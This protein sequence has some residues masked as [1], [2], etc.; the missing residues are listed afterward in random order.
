MAAP[1]GNDAGTV[2]QP[3]PID[4]P[5]IIGLCGVCAGLGEVAASSNPA[6]RVR[7]LACNGEGDLDAFRLNAA[8]EYGRNEILE[9]MY[10]ALRNAGKRQMTVR[11]LRDK[12]G[13]S[14]RS[15]KEFDERES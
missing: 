5:I 14:Y 9:W 4:K 7:C 15:K 10:A 2:S 3:K 6:K 8:Y 13:E 12:V 1:K 11:E